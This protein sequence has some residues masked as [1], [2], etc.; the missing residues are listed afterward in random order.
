[1]N[2]AAT[3]Y[4]NSIIVGILTENE[5]N[6]YQ[7]EYDSEYYNNG[8]YPAVSLTMPKTKRV[9]KSEYLFPFFFNMLTEGVNRKA[10]L[11]QLH[12]SE[13]DH[14]GLLVATSSKD[15]IGAITVKQITPNG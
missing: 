7:F 10:Q 4:R 2:R 11:R 1:M 13:N 3:V 14:F 8:Q 9:Y 5:N 12:I 6:G 15:S